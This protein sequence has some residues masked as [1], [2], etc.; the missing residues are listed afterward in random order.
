MWE[1]VIMDLI[2]LTEPP[3]MYIGCFRSIPRVTTYI[4]Q[5]AA[6]NAVHLV[7]MIY[8]L[9]FLSA[10]VSDRRATQRVVRNVETIADKN[11][12][13]TLFY[14]DKVAQQKG[15]PITRVAGHI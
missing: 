1:G 8:P 7:L 14:N 2:S 5:I 11:G 9:F 3:S 12:P 6:A 10:M 15:E 4:A 13:F